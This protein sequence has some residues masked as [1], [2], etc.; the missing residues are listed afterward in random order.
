M[1][2]GGLRCD[3]ARETVALLF[4]KPPDGRPWVG[5]DWV[6]DEA[7]VAQVC[8]CQRVA[9]GERMGCGQR[10][11][12]GLACYDFDIGLGLTGL[13]PGEGDVDLPGEDVV[14]LVEQEFA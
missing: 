4:S 10:D 11:Y 8:E 2:A 6:R 3:V 9:R 13:Q 12:T 5:D 14:G 1:Q 7:F